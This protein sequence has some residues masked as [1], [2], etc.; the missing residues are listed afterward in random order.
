GAVAEDDL[1]TLG[2]AREGLRIGEVAPFAV[3]D[4]H[5]Q[6]LAGRGLGGEGRVG[7][8]DADVRPVTAELQAIVGQE[9]AGEE[10]RLAQ[11]LKTITNAQNQSP[12]I[13]K[14]PDFGHDRRKTRDGPRSQV[15]A[16]GE[17]TGE[18]QGIDG[19]KLGRGVPDIVNRGLEN[20]VEN[21]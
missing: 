16:V 7:A 3:G 19:G 8:L 6:D 15:V 2:K 12:R 4:G 9:R 18:N 21:V 17:A 20:L 13:G 10:A 1:P 5:A 14:A 11:Y